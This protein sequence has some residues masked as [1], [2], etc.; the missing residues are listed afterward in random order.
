MTTPQPQRDQ[1]AKPSSPGPAEPLA[2]DAILHQT[3]QALV[4]RQPLSAAE[5]QALEDVA[6][7]M[8]G[9]PLETVVAELVL[10]VLKEHVSAAP[11]F[12]EWGPG[13]SRRVAATLLD[14]PDAKPRLEALWTRLQGG[15]P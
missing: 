12:R 15:H 6:R 11:G 2:I 9:K 10:A 14:D 13:L 1:P 3:S 5:K 7:R 4:S 8:Q